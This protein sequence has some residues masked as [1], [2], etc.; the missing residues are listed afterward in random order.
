M[1][2]HLTQV[3]LRAADHGIAR[4][5]G[6]KTDPGHDVRIDGQASGAPSRDVK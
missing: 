4:S 2:V 3:R 1:A 5:G 6:R